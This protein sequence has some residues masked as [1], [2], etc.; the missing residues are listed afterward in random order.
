[1][2]CSSIS[3]RSACPNGLS[4]KDVIE[5]SGRGRPHRPR[6]AQLRLLV[7]VP[8]VRLAP[9][10]MADAREQAAASGE[11]TVQRHR[12]ATMS[13]A[14]IDEGKLEAFMGQAVMDMGAIISAPL[15]VIGEKLG[16]Y[17]AMAGAGPPSSEEPAQRPAVGQPPVRGRVRH[18]AARGRLLFTGAHDRHR[19]PAAH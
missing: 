4:L 8:I 15:F 11:R 19:P 18:P 9:Y 16:L 5:S 2:P 14:E 1:M 3:A 12:G 17:K 13:A 7:P 6:R 10:R